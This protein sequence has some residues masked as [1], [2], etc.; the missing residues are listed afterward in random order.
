MK[1]TFPTI[2]QYNQHF[3]QNGSEGFNLLRNI[4]LLASRNV[5]V[6]IFLFGS[7]AYAAVFKG[8]H[9]GKTFAIRCFLTIDGETVSRY[10]VI[11]D[12]LSNISA[13]WKVDFQFLD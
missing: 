5:P 8:I 3:Q 7:G 6:K 12:Y 13:N 11:G 10:K 4:R 1:R 9:G 2:G